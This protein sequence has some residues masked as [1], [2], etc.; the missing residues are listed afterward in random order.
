MYNVYVGHK[1]TQLTIGLPALNFMASTLFVEENL[2]VVRGYF[3]V[4]WQYQ[5]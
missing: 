5:R 3:C 4:C 1:P 2:R